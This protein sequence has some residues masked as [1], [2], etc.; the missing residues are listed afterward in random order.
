M[1][2]EFNITKSEARSFLLQKQLLM[3]P[4][5]KAKDG[6]EKVFDHLR[7]VQYDPL[8]PF[9]RNPDLVLQSRIDDYHPEGYFDWLYV[10]KQGIECYDKAL[11]IIPIEDFALTSHNRKSAAQWDSIQNFLKTHERELEETLRYIEKNGPVSSSE[12]G[13]SKRVS[14]MDWYGFGSR[15]GKAAL[16]ALWKTGRIVV[17]KRIKGNKYYDLPHKVY[18]GDY[19]GID[20]RVEEEHIL[21]RVNSVGIMREN[22]MTDAWRGIGDAKR[23]NKLVEELTKKGEL[24]SV[25]IEGVKTK[26]V[27]LASDK[28]LLDKKVKFDGIMRFIAPLDTL[29]WDRNMI[30]ELFNF[31]YR[32]EVYVPAKKRE[33]GYYVLPVLYKDQ[34]VGRIEPVFKN[35]VLTIKNFWKEDRVEWTKIMDKAL[36]LAIKR[37][38]KYLK[39]E[40]VDIPTKY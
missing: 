24:I 39:A 30:E 26:Y 12:V 1:C 25:E 21:R 33:Y 23:K 4:N 17:T 31:R 3:G 2:M 11:C 40:K 29:I 36:E 7:I 19:F 20:R 10:K 38:G 8:N 28:S 15:Y 13:G 5:L 22:G 35:G 6:I 9:G 32:W 37:F 14:G 27:I 18:K 16:E 34:F